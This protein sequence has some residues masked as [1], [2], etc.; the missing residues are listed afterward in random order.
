[1]GIEGVRVIPLTPH[2]DDRGSLTEVFRASWFPAGFE[3][4]QANL[5]LSAPKVLRGL[6]VH[7]VQAD[8]WYL[9]SGRAFVGLFDVRAGS[10]THRRKAE[11]ALDAATERVGMFIP[12]GVAH[13]FYAE[14]EV[15]LQYLVDRVFDGTDEFGVAWDDPEV[16]IAWPERS[17][18]LS[19]RD[20]SNPS[21]Q[22]FLADAPSFPD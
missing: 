14:T 8:L 6:H 1:V 13:G 11:L 20:R 7:R 17:P 9:V 15:A 3:V 21:L 2:I 18:V 10:A 5:S 22:R 16:G 12:P 19:E 4:E